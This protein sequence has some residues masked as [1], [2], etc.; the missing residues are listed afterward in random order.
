MIR[1]DIYLKSGRSIS[2][3]VTDADILT[4][5]TNNELVGYRLSYDPA[6]V[7]R[8]LWIDIKEIAAITKREVPDERNTS[9]SDD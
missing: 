8:L 1:L 5:Q 6:A 9:G 4:N 2:L 3:D 7:S